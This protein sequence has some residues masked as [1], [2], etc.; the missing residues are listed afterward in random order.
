[1]FKREISMNAVHNIVHY[2]KY[3]R[4]HFER[5]VGIFDLKDRSTFNSQFMATRLSEQIFRANSFN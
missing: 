3:I 1:M 5:Y 4:L 2:D